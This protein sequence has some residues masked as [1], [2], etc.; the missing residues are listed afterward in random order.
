MKTLRHAFAGAALASIAAMLPLAAPAEA[1]TIVL[2]GYPDQIQFID[3]VSGKVTGLTKLDTGLPDNIQLSADRSKIYVTTLTTS[4]IEVLDAKSHQVVNKFSLNTPSVRYRFKGGVPDPTGR[5]FYAVGERFDKEADL[6]KVSK[7]QYYTIDL[8]THEVVRTVDFDE[9]DKAPGWSTSMA[10]A[11]DGK[12]LYVF[13]DK[14]RVI[15]TKTFKIVDRIDLAKPSS[16]GLQ[17]VS[18]GGTLNTVSEAGKYISVFN[19][20]DPYIHNKVFGV[21]RFDLTSRSFTFDPIGPAP[22][23][24]EGLQVTPDGKDG[25]TVAVI[26]DL[27][28]QRCEFWHFDLTTN[29]AVDKAEF[30]CRRRFYFAM[31]ADGQKLY[32]YGAGYDIAVYDAKTLKPEADWELRHDITM[33][34]LLH[35]P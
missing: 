20:E 10:I 3:D 30:E 15:D 13:D 23:R 25:Y 28:K 21:A 1:G 5:L 12:T 14:V 7:P 18:F 29:T 22:D 6:Y 33:A 24:M 9:K 27:G 31:S 19:A 26:G 4:G 11:P 2:G 32:I 8:K 17:D 34:G 35:L 16:S